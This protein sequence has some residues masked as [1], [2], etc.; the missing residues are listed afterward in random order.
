MFAHLLHQVVIRHGRGGLHLGLQWQLNLPVIGQRFLQR[1]NIPLL[2]HRLYRHV[3]ANQI[4]K[5]AFPQGVDLRRQVGGIQN[6]VALLVNHLALVVGHVIVF[7]QLLAH[8]KVA[9]LHFALRALNAA[10]HDAGLNRFAVGH[11]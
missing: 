4:S 3:L 2:F 10:R 5:T 9:G 11:F 7:Q 8:V 1:G 6:F